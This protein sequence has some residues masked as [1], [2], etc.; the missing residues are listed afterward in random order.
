ME[1][2]IMAKKY[3]Q[4]IKPNIGALKGRV[5]MSIIETIRNTPKPDHT[6]SEKRVAEFTKRVLAERANGI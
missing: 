2:V 3:K 5:G 4:P 6:V 1:G